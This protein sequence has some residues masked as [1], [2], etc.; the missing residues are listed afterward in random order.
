M[1]KKKIVTWLLSLPYSAL[2]KVYKVSVA[3]QIYVYNLYSKGTYEMFI[4]SKCPCMYLYVLCCAQWVSHVQQFATP[5]TIACQAPLSVG[6]LLA[7]ILECVSIPF[8][9]DLPSPVIKPRSPALQVESSLTKP[10]GKPIYLHLHAYLSIYT[11][12][13]THTH[14]PIYTYIYTHSFKPRHRITQLLAAMV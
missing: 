5:W 8:P 14:T 4:F 12:T 11:H 6:I 3:Y 13:H 7:I 2:D 10:P 1:L 9:G